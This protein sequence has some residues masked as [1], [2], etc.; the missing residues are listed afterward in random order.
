M[1]AANNSEQPPQLP[2]DHWKK[3]GLVCGAVVAG[4]AIGKRGST[5]LTAGMAAVAGLKLLAK[6]PPPNPRT[7]P[8]TDCPAFVAL[9]EAPVEALETSPG[10]YETTPVE[11]V[12]PVEVPIE[13]GSSTAIFDSLSVQGSLSDTDFADPKIVQEPVTPPAFAAEE[14]LVPESQIAAETSAEADFGTIIEAATDFASEPENTSA[15]SSVVTACFEDAPCA[16][17]TDERLAESASLSE[18]L[19]EAPSLECEISA[20]A[21]NAP[22]SDPQV[23]ESEAIQQQDLPPAELHALALISSPPVSTEPPV[24]SVDFT[25]AFGPFIWEAGVDTVSWSDTPS[26]TVWYGLQDHENFLEESPDVEAEIA[27]QRLAEVTDADKE[28]WLKMLEP[29]PSA[30]PVEE[31]EESPLLGQF[32]VSDSPFISASA[33][34]F[35]SP[36]APEFAAEPAPAVSLSHAVPEAFLET[37]LISEPTLPDALDAASIEVISAEADASPAL[38]S[39]ATE[40]E[41]SPL[42]PAQPFSLFLPIPR[43]DSTS[44]SLTS[45][46]ILPPENAQALSTMESTDPDADER[47]SGFVLMEDEDAPPLTTTTLSDRSSPFLDEEPWTSEGFGDMLNKYGIVSESRINVVQSSPSPNGPHLDTAQFTVRPTVPFSAMPS[48]SGLEIRS[49]TALPSPKARSAS[50]GS[51]PEPSPVKLVVHRSVE[52]LAPTGRPRRHLA[53]AALLMTVLMALV[54]GVF[55]FTDAGRNSF[56]IGWWK[57]FSAETLRLTKPVNTVNPVIIPSAANANEGRVIPISTHS[58]AQRI[59]VSEQHEVSLKSASAS[60]PH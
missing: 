23:T 18:S 16:T 12:S 1:A 32:P 20:T 19:T 60:L 26:E 7:L 56:D 40:T 35:E 44:P 17:D 10:C 50:D 27:S 25:M 29:P 6:R 15:G 34:E 52:P 3:L 4:W 59:N 22:S 57:Q 2:N 33:S 43:P 53:R 46:E 24:T 45:T 47:L 9:E 13:F 58:P 55:V 36:T 11:D 28:A 14:I 30:A 37:P 51:L 39:A 31:I 41:I 54:V 8:D 48:P 5:G 49:K 42:Q 38:P 21:A